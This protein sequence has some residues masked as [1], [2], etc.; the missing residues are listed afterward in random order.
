MSSQITTVIYL[1]FLGIF[2]FTYL[3]FAIEPQ[4][5]KNE[6]KVWVAT[7]FAVTIVAFFSY[8]FLL[9][10]FLSA[11]IIFF[12]SKLVKNKL[13]LYCVLLLAIPTYAEKLSVLFSISYT[14]ELSLLLLLPL[15]KSLTPKAVYNHRVDLP[16]FGEPIVEKL[17][18]AF[19]ILKSVLYYRGLSAPI[20]PLTYTEIIR[21]WFYVFLEFFLPYYVASRY[22]RNF[23]EFK[24]VIIAFMSATMLVGMIAM[25]ELGRSWLLYGELHRLL[26]ILDW[27]QGMYIGRS[28]FIRATAS[29]EHP[30]ALGLAMLIGIGIYLFISRLIK[31]KFLRLVGFLIVVGGLI[32]PLSRGPWMGATLMLLIFFAMGHKKGRNFSLFISAVIVGIPALYF[33]PGGQKIINLL[34]FIGQVDKFNVDYRSNLIDQSLLV[35]QNHPLFGVF[36]PTLEP[37]MQVLIQGQGI[38][39]LVNYYLEMTLT[40]GIIGLILFFSAC[41]IVL[42]TLLKHINK[43]PDK[44]SMEYICGKSLFAIFASVLVTISTM[45]GLS[46]INTMVF[47]LIGLIVS[48]IRVTKDVNTQDEAIISEVKDYPVTR[49]V[50]KS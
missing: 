42:I 24:T 12:A 34:P 27:G 13:A 22:I 26:G 49:V 18:I 41:M 10:S 25:F 7:W 28:N 5:F 19:L 2:T 40:N 31:N 37:E 46:I 23:A 35:I 30:L 48:Y 17:M 3:K 44:L 32:A 33:I 36:D 1:V 45:S 43:M 38:I 21:Q 15:L 16:K 29:L 4:L 39:D 14:R 20:E 11:G 50:K 47:M 8:N 9:F 6:F